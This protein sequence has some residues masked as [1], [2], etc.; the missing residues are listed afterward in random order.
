[1]GR[2]SKIMLSDVS[3]TKRDKYDQ[4]FSS[5]QSEK[6]P[7]SVYGNKYRDPPPDILSPS[8]LSPQGSGI[9]VEQEEESVRSRGIKHTKKMKPSKSCHYLYVCVCIIL[10][11]MNSYMF[12]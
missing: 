6:L 1:M 3:Q 5:A 7:H 12:K 2:I 10:K 8:N 4:C 9:L 11:C